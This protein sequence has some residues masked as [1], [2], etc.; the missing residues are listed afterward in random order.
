MKTYGFMTALAFSMAVTCWGQAGAE[1]SQAAA[2]D[3]P[4]TGETASA[5]AIA[6]ARATIVGVHSITSAE[7]LDFGEVGSGTSPGA[8]VLP[9]QGGRSGTGGVTLGKQ[10]DPGSARFEIRGIPRTAFSFALPGSMYLTSGAN[11]M[12]V[13]TFTSHTG[14]NGTLD[15]DGETWLRV[16][17]TL[18]VGANQVAGDYTGTFAVTVT[19][20]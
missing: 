7:D 18:R 4:T 13:D 11:S 14:G 9:P 2:R 17:A 6:T 5:S 10:G 16:G 19:F 3:R 8:V 20:N 1:L 12:L 15:G